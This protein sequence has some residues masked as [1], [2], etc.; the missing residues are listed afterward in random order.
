MAWRTAKVEE[1]RFEFIEA[2]KSREISVA[3]LCQNFQ[4]T[5]KTG[6]KW[7]GRFRKEGKE[8]LKDRSRAPHKQ[9]GQTAEH[10]EDKI[11]KVKSKYKD[12][13]PK[14][15]LAH[16]KK[17]GLG[18]KW[19]SST[20]IGNI[21]DKHGLVV[22]RKYRR[23][24][25]AK[26]DPLAHAKAPNDLWCIDFK[27]W[28]KTKDGVKCEPFT[29]TDAASRFI[30][31]CSPLPSNKGADVWKT[32]KKLFHEYGLPRYLRHDNGPPFATNG[33]GRLSSLSV[34]LIKA[35]ITPEWIEPGKPY[36]NGRHERMHRTMKEEGTFPLQ[37]TLKEQQM[38]LKEFRL[39]FNSERPHES[40]GQV[41]PESIYV[42]SHRVW[43]G[44][45]QAPEYNS[46]FIVKQVRG[47]G[48]ISWNG[49]DIYIGKTL[50]NEFIGLKEYDEGHLVYYG[51][52]LLGVINQ[53]GDFIT[54]CKPIRPNRKH[55]TRCY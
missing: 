44:K 46:E 45:L 1:Q 53:A 28:F 34:N 19:P 3:D 22:P 26:T 14:K 23:R 8:G 54:P 21:L 4:I 15:I 50:K 12:W 24:Y 9:S 43:E 38:K 52:V 20:T 55:K 2:Y 18:E 37:L 31:Y 16:L 33:A 40:L 41:T 32:L 42:P 11:L 5:T 7:L 35:G 10:L 27:G 39:Y 6:Y 47:R 49:T 25:P 17:D 29:V 36:Q 48:Q 51:P 30:L 13:G